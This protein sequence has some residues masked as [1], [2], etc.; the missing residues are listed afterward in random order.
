MWYIITNGLFYVTPSLLNA[1]DY[2][3]LWLIKENI[4]T[5]SVTKWSKYEEL[6]SDS[7]CDCAADSFTDAVVRS[8]NVQSCCTSLYIVHY[9]QVAFLKLTTVCQWLWVLQWR[10][11]SCHVLVYKVN[12][13]NTL[14]Q[15]QYNWPMQQGNFSVECIYL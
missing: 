9:Q 11:H 13:S 6:T 2:C 7:D 1:T 4:W 15:L 8:T 14:H 3:Y 12:S 5:T 10:Q